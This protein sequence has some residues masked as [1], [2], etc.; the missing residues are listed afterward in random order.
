MERPRLHLIRTAAD[1][2][3]FSDL[4]AGSGQP[5]GGQPAPPPAGQTMRFAVSNI[6]IKDGQVWF[7][8]RVLHEQHAADR[9]QIGVPFI[10]N[11][12]ADVDI[13]VQPMV[14]MTIDGSPFRILGMAKPF[15]ATP[16]SV[17]DLKLK[18]L[19]LP[20]YAAYVEHSL[21]VRIAGGS[22]ST[23]VQVHFI[24]PESGPVIQLGGSVE[25]DGLD[26][27]DGSNAPLLAFKRGTVALINVEPLGK[28]AS[29]GA[30]VLD[31]VTSNLMLRRDGAT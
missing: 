15:A 26:V 10:A 23:S 19:D 6:L 7:E 3:N 25:V 11:L 16:D 4:L 8:D 13:F 24:Q 9:I 30:I 22:L 12:P 5:Q 29:L 17:L 27:R 31:G 1:R 20:R 21:P 18:R 2:F 28:V 14:T